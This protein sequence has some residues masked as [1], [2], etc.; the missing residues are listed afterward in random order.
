MLR[1]HNWAQGFSIYRRNETARLEYFLNN[2]HG[3]QRSGKIR[4]IQGQ[5]KLREFWSFEKS[6]GTLRKSLE[7]RG[8]IDF[9]QS[10][11]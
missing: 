2:L 5:R 3:C 10:C 11:R 4:E 6:Q 1:F 7:S 8:K 9:L